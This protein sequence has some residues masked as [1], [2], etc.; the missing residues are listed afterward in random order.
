[1]L[2]KA[3]IW[4]G[5]PAVVA[6]DGRCEKAW[7]INNRPVVQLS[8]NPDDYEFLADGELG[9]AP[10]NPGTYEGQ[11]GKPSDYS[12]PYR[13]NKWC[14]RECERSKI[15]EPAGVVVLPDYG[16]RVGNIPVPMEVP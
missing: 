9:E 2:V 10:R 6:C 7:G 14:C 11:H 13:Q 12:D 5:N 1:M 8:D 4:F 15:V 16:K 3:I